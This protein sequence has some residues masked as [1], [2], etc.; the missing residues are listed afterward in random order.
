MLVPW[1]EYEHAF[2]PAAAAIY[3]SI[4]APATAAAATLLHTASHAPQLCQGSSGPLLRGRRTQA[5]QRIQHNRKVPARP[6]MT[7]EL[8]RA[9]MVVVVV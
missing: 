6:P 4:T 1:A 5:R 7:T 8:P 3:V 2:S 9:V